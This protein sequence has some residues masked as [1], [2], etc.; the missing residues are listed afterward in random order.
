MATCI[1]KPIFGIFH[2]CYNCINSTG[3]RRIVAKNIL[4]YIKQKLELILAFVF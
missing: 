2:W 3:A 4:Q 1:T